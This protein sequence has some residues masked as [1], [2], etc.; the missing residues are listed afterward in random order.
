[1]QLHLRFRPDITPEKYAMT[2]NNCYEYSE[3]KNL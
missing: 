2:Y 3:G 1:V